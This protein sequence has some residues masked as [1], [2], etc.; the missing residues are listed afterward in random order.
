MADAP[1]ATELPR[2][3]GTVT[4]RHER[5]G[6]IVFNPFF[7]EE[8]ELDPFEA[9]VATTFTGA[10]PWPA[11]E[12]AAAARFD[13]PIEEARLRAWKTAGK[14]ERIGGLSRAEGVPSEAVLSPETRV[15]PEDGPA[16]R[17]PKQVIWDVTYACNLACPHC[18]TASGKARSNELDTASAHRLVERLV[19]ARVLYLALSGGEP[20]LRPDILE[21][22][23]HATS[24]N[25]R[26]DVATNGVVLPEGIRRGL[27]DLPVFQVQVS[28]DGI[29]DTHDRFRGRRGAFEASCRTVKELL[30]EGIGVSLS[31]TA[32]AENIGE[33]DRII[34]LALSLGCRGFKAIPFIAAGR[35]RENEARLRLSA[36]ELSI[37]GRTLVRRRAE[38]AGRLSIATDAGFPFLWEAA[39]GHDVGPDDGHMGCSAGHDTMSIGAD[40]TAYPCPFLQ[41]LPLG[42]VLDTPI[43]Q[44]WRESETLGALRELSKSQLDEPCRTCHFAPGECHGGCRAAALLATGRLTGADPC[45]PRVASPHRALPVLH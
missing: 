41:T 33:L 14:I 36:D 5:S 34:D 13:L 29:G 28:V 24:E 19:E 1:T 18:L 26:V 42:S 23:E 4:L 32:T 15:F 43:E 25:L 35:G 31:T 16:L 17:S 30:D 40:G 39:T 3:L 8:V 12:S 10:H 20:L 21:I 7:A 27:R 6:A 38:L 11:I 9:W 44:I 45:C 2:L 37:L 22:V